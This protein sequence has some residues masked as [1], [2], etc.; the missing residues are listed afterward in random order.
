MTSF[1]EANKTVHPVEKQWHYPILTKH[2]FVPET[3]EATGFVRNYTYKH[4][5][6]RVIVCTTGSSADYWTDQHTKEHG[7][8][9]TLEKHITR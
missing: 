5:D 4:E 2:G 9:A 7:Y 8:W 3:K 1:D 6:G